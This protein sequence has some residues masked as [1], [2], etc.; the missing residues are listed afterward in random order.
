MFM[1]SGSPAATGAITVTPSGAVAVQMPEPTAM[2]V[3]VGILVSPLSNP[4][5][6]R[7]MDRQSRCLMYSVARIDGVFAQHESRRGSNPGNTQNEKSFYH[8]SLIDLRCY[9]E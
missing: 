7:R 1:R 5:P 4:P 2:S 8:Q 3:V 6:L 9:L